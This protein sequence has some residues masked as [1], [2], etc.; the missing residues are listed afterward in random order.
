MSKNTALLI[1]FVLLT[2]VSATG[3]HCAEKIELLFDGQEGP[4]VPDRVGQRVQLE[5]RVAGV[6][7]PL[8]LCKPLYRKRIDAIHRNR[9]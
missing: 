4:F 6:V 9:Q 5:A 2:L 3:A 7:L 8:R 1:A